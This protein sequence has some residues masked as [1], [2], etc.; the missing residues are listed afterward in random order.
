MRSSATPLHL[1]LLPPASCFNQRFLRLT[2]QFHAHAFSK[3][4]CYYCDFPVVALGADGAPASPPQLARQQPAIE[5][6]VETLCTEITA[7]ARLQ[8]APLDTVYLGGGTPSLVPPPL[9]ARVLAALRGRFG[10]AGDAEVTLE[11]DPG[12]FDLHRLRAYQAAGVTRFSVG[13]Q[14]FDEVRPRRRPSSRAEDNPPLERALDACG[15][16][17][18]L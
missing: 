17:T 2:R 12:T 18:A 13:V 8:R 4:K 16:R 14:S 5:A 9:L 7:H 1:S 11:A 3:R 10:I 15:L 6:Y